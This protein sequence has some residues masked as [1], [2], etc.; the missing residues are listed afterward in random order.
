M[1]WASSSG[2]SRHLRPASTGGIVVGAGGV[3]RKRAGQAPLDRGERAPLLELEHALGMAGVGDRAEAEQ[4]ELPGRVE[5]QRLEDERRDQREPER[6]VDRALDG[7]RRERHDEHHE[8]EAV[9]VAEVAAAV[10]MCFCVASSPPP[11]PATPADTANARI[12][13]RVGLTPI[14]CAAV[15][16]PRSAA[17]NCPVVPRRTK[18]TKTD[19]TTSTTTHKQEEGAVVGEADRARHPHRA[20]AAAHP[21]ARARSPSR[22]R[23]RP[24]ACPSDRKMPPRRRS[25]I[26]IDAPT[27]AATSAP[28][29]SVGSTARPK[30]DDEL[31]GGERADA[32]ERRLRERDLA[33]HAGD[34]RDR[35]EDHRVDHRGGEDGRPTSR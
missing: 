33:R 13:I 18:I 23:A 24:R 15:S 9:E 16:L 7:A 26:A 12:R 29:N 4:H 25:G 20:R 2:I 34:H 22:T 30:T 28:M 5:T 31:R 10:A 6:G 11:S 1:P 35:Q 3:T 21:A 14:D 17:R 8:E 32:R 27:A 19:A